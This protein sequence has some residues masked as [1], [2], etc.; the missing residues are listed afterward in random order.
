MKRIV[1]I[2]TILSAAIALTGCGEMAMMYKTHSAVKQ[3]IK[4]TREMSKIQ[5]KP[6]N[7]E[8]SA[9]YATTE[10][11]KYYY[12]L[13]KQYVTDETTIPA[14]VKDPATDPEA[15]AIADES[16]AGTKKAMMAS[17]KR[18]KFNQNFA[19]TVIKEAQKNA[20]YPIRFMTDLP[21]GAE[22]GYMTFVKG[23]NTQYYKSRDS[24]TLS[25]VYKTDDVIAVKD[26]LTASIGAFL[27]PTGK[28]K[29][30]MAG[31]R[32]IMEKGVKDTQKLVDLAR[33][34]LE[35]AQ[36]QNYNA[37]Q[38]KMRQDHL[39]RMEASL[40]S[41]KEK[42][43]N[44]EAS[45]VQMFIYTYQKPDRSTDYYQVMLNYEASDAV[46]VMFNKGIS[47]K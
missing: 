30:T 18:G 19:M 42:L 27:E 12:E 8:E 14:V 23:Q 39:D 5:S 20:K 41:Q 16:V 37:Y 36:K 15:K 31:G 32:D 40:K 17:V 1:M 9:Q 4:S 3:Q 22:K 13:L 11:S 2:L 45:K 26:R 7:I 6:L 38:I 44:S 46:Q 28:W 47:Y 43:E 33:E 10:E 34:S 29:K 25:I 21:A 24:Y 35:S